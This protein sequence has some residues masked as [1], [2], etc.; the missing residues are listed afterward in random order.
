MKS[1][2]VLNNKIY[3]RVDEN[4]L[5]GFGHVICCLALAELKYQLK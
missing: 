4:N 1:N 5:I 2:K 3:L